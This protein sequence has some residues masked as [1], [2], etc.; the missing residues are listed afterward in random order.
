MSDSGDY[1][2][3]P[4]QSLAC[5]I[6][7]RE[8]GGY[9][10][11]ILKHQVDGFLPSQ[12]DYAIG[13]VVIAKFVCWDKKKVLLS[14][15]SNPEYN[16]DSIDEFQ[17]LETR[18]RAVDL[19]TPPKDEDAIANI[20]MRDYDP[21][22]I[23][24]DLESGRRTGCFKVNNNSNKSRGAL[25]LKSGRVVGC[26][27]NSKSHPKSEETSE[28]LLGLLN[29]LTEGN[30]FCCLYD[31]DDEMVLPLAAL[32]MGRSIERDDDLGDLQY[33]EKLS[34]RFKQGRETAIICTTIPNNNQKVLSKFY[35]G[36]FIGSFHRK[37]A[38]FHKSLDSVLD[39]F[40]QSESPEQGEGSGYLV[41]AWSLPEEFLNAGSEQGYS[42]SEFWERV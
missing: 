9:A 5:R 21:L 26:V 19:I 14:L 24:S 1:K 18:R 41:E 38:Q 37:D 33:F 11:S 32:F 29:T 23:V 27:F 10:V 15:P 7:S 36:E 2:F 4:G 8:P 3:S 31:L 22:W 6:V 12:Y 35:N 34:K 25:V 30:T 28:S 40:L 20:R 13:D 16:H 42:L 39:L 17:C